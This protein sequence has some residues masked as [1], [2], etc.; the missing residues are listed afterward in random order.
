MQSDTLGC[1]I[2][3][4]RH[5]YCQKWG[6][7]V[8]VIISFICFSFF[9]VVIDQSI[10]C[11]CRQNKMH[12]NFHLTDFEN[13]KRKIGLKIGQLSSGYSHRDNLNHASQCE[14]CKLLC[15]FPPP[16]LPT[17]GQNPAG[18][19]VS[20]HSRLW[21]HS[22]IVECQKDP[23]DAINSMICLSTTPGLSHGKFE[24]E[25]L[26]SYPDYNGAVQARPRADQVLFVSQDGHEKKDNLCLFAA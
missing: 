4:D 14:R 3:K 6:N 5:I 11:I 22:N 24:F 15:A 20:N 1:I 26:F 25:H 19:S 23:A 10:Y 7:V 21:L 8:K 9:S 12:P 13:R 17:V 16:H 18:A 2:H